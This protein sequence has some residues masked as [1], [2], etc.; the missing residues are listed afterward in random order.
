M[1]K[2]FGATRIGVWAIKHVAAPL[3]RWL[4]R[5]TRG[6]FLSTGK[7]AGPILLLTTTGRRSGQP[8]TTPVFYLRDGSRLV[9]CNTNPGFERTNPWVLNLRAL[10]TAT[11]QV[12][13]HTYNCRAREADAA[14][15]AHYWPLLTRMWPAYQEHY[16]RS[17]QRTVFILQKVQPAPH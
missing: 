7:P 11:V 10:P 14:E 1:I 13:A 12:D 6:K 4:Y 9:I 3:D 5:R 17:G 8:R 2:W 16:N 15:L